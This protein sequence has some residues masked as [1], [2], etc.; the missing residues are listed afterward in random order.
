MGSVSGV[1]RP[2][3]IGDGLRR[4]SPDE[5]VGAA[6][7]ALKP[8]TARVESRFSFPSG[9]HPDALFTIAADSQVSVFVFN[10]T[11]DRDPDLVLLPAGSSSPLRLTAEECWL[12][13]RHEASVGTIGGATLSGLGF[14]FEAEAPVIF[15][16]YRLHD[17]SEP[18]IHAVAADLKRPRFAQR[19]AD[20]RS[21]RPDEALA[22]TAS[23]KLR[24][25]VEVGWSDVLAGGLGVVAGIVGAE[26]PLSVEVSAAATVDAAVTVADDFSIVF[27]RDHEGTTR[28]AVRKA[29]SRRAACDGGASIAVELSDPQQLQQALEDVGAGLLGCEHATLRRVV[30]A[31]SLDELTDAERTAVQELARR[32]GL[33]GIVNNFT[34]LRDKLQQIDGVLAEAVAE[35]ATAKLAAAFTYEYDRVAQGSVLLQAVLEPEALVVHH[36]T[37]C[38]GELTPVIA[39]IRN[40]CPGLV[41][42]RYLHRESLE[43]TQSLGFTL[44]IGP[45]LASGK[46]RRTLG[47][48][49]Q[50]NL[51]GRPKVSTLGLGAYEGRWLADAAEWIVDFNAAMPAFAAGPVAL[52]NEFKLG[53]HLA[54]T[55]R[56]VKLT[57][58]ELDAYLDAAS[59]WG[60]FDPE[61]AEQIRPRLEPALG[62]PAA[63]AV[64]LLVD[65]ESLR[66]LLPLAAAGRDADFAAALGAAM[67][68]RPGSPG[69]AEPDRRRELYGALW[70][71]FMDNPDVPARTLVEYARRYLGSRHEAELGFLEES[72]SKLTPTSTFVGLAKLANQ[73]TA[74]AWRE[75]RSGAALLHEALSS[76]AEDT[77]T[78]ERAF[79]SMVNLWAQS[80][81]VRALG[82]YLLELATTAGIVHHL[83]RTLTVTY[84]KGD[85]E[86][87]L[88]VAA[89]AT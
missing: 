25:A 44:G 72:Y 68:W 60:V 31:A 34:V 24:V 26:G 7:G 33:E 5:T 85:D 3:R 35:L 20:V 76:S 18:L 57:P 19:L 80:H 21:L 32:L 36:G 29:V 79:S 14:H 41:L 89:P 71:Y 86:R 63:V 47:R 50:E 16:D 67:P 38:R 78:F 11:E 88:V 9:G 56:D 42:E 69:R 10:S 51:A 17:R 74:A 2:A 15:A 13:V 30:D 65:D 1:P 52:V 27:S 58:E 62:R 28:V 43:R 87:A 4:L 49:V 81:L 82:A 75:F 64:Q 6:S 22:F 59:L 54:W 66:A 83:T 46:Q 8:L 45:W 23:G 77:D 73:G 55:W 40:G 61:E 12:K 39:A 37:L 70:G 48:I 53:L 84:L